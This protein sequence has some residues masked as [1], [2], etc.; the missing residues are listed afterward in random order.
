VTGGLATN[1]DQVTV[2]EHAAFAVSDGRGDVVPGGYHG[3]YVADTR[4]LSRFVLRLGGRRLERLA[5]GTPDHQ[6]ADF[7]LANPWMGRLMA[8]SVSVV[9]DRRIDDALAERIQV[10]SYEM[11]P[12]RLRLTLHLGADFADIFEVLGHARMDRSVSVAETGD[13]VRFEYRR[14]GYHRSTSVVVDRPFRWEHD[15]L[16]FDLVLE[17]G[18]PWDLA[19]RIETEEGPLSSAAYARSLPARRP[20]DSARVDRWAARVPRLDS[21]DTR[22]VRAWQ[23]SV[24]D[25][26]ALLMAEPGGSFIPAAGVPWFMAVF[27]RD[28]SITSLQSL[29]AGGEI[30]YGTLRELAAVQGRTDDGFRDE[31]RGKIAHEVR[32]GELAALDRVPHA[33]Y[34]GSVDAT[35]LYLRLFAEACRWSGWL[36]THDRDGVRINGS[37]P[38]VLRRLL[39]AAERALA[40]IDTRTAGPD[41]LI[42]FQRRNRKGIRNQAWKDSFDSYRFADGRM[43]PTPIAAVEVQGYAVAAWRAMADVFDAL[44]RGDDA[45]RRRAVA[46]AMVRRIDDAFWMPDAGTYAMGLDRYGHQIDAVTSNPGHLLWSG[47]VS[48]ERAALV[49]ERLTAP[50]M[51]TGWGIR[52]MSA[53]MAAYNPISYHNG[54]IWPHDNSLI[55]AGLARYGETARAWRVADALLDAVAQDAAWRLP[56]LFAGFDRATTPALVGYPV[57]CSPQAWASATVFHQVQTL[58]GLEPAGDAAHLAPFGDGPWVTLSDL[59]IGGWRGDIDSRSS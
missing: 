53:E 44:G 29:I 22:L 24:R 52:T 45:A 54:S 20:T 49:A 55:A 36:I 13:G 26:R 2:I 16:G 23:A 6:R 37:M 25:M 58:L 42:W 8:N 40:W 51:F 38:T 15:R 43:A 48:G 18:A 32:R 12:L 59:R 5:V 4:Y 33:R 34:Y 39:P 56:E 46:D 9:R 35:P 19:L 11:T 57:A 21:D 50:D 10:T 1:L 14:A 17:R 30:A 7:H 41:G 31:E 27:G 3:L 28:A 47:A